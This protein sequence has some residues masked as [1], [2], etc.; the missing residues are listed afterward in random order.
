[1][2]ID[3]YS[4]S[5]AVYSAA[6]HNPSLGLEWAKS[7]DVGLPQPDVVLFLELS[8]AEAAKRGGYGEERYEKKEFQD[9]VRTLFVKLRETAGENFKT[10][11]AGRSFEEVESSIW[12]VVTATLK[13]VERDDGPLGHI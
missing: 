1:M 9:R 5:G 7:P 13:H 2:V 10:I 3:R 11:D 8:P 12:D 4:Y 6:K